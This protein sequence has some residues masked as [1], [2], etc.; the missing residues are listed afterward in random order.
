MCEFVLA[1]SLLTELQALA[2]SDLLPMLCPGAFHIVREVQLS[3]HMLDLQSLLGSADVAM[4][5]PGSLYTNDLN[6]LFF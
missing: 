5:S 3:Q 2:Q 4:H 1:R 6:T